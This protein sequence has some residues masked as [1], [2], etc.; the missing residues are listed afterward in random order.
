MKCST[1]KR[2]Y[3]TEREAIDA[4]IDLRARNNYRKGSGP[5][6]VYQCEDCGQWHF[7]S[8]GPEHELLGLETVQKKI[9]D[10]REALYWER[11]LRF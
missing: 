7:T 1:G 10:D 11:K 8:K 9:A 6:N 4:L 5:I 2:I 3:D